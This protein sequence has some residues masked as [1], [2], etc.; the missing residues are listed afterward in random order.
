MHDIKFWSEFGLDIDKGKSKAIFRVFN[1]STTL[2]VVFYALII[3]LIVIF[4]SFD[5]NV[6]KNSY[7]I[8][9][10]FVLALVFTLLSYTLV[11]SARKDT[12]KLLDNKN[13][14]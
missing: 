5:N 7:V 2:L 13:K 10:M 9:G 3:S 4:D 8:I 14:K 1:N 12:A 11:Y 6:M